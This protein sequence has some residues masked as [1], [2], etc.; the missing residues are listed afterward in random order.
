[1]DETFT[2]SAQPEPMKTM[3]GLDTSA[4]E[5]YYAQSEPMKMNEGHV[6]FAGVFSSS[7]RARTDNGV[8]G[9]PKIIARM[10]L[11]NKRTLERKEIGKLRNGRNGQDSKLGRN[12]SML[13]SCNK[14][15]LLNSATKK[16]VEK[17]GQGI[18]EVF[19]NFHKK[20]VEKGGVDK[21]SGSRFD[22]LCEEMDTLMSKRVLKK[23]DKM[24][25]LK[26]TFKGVIKSKAVPEVG[27][28]DNRVSLG[29]VEVNMDED[30][31]D[32]ESAYSCRPVRRDLL[33]SCRY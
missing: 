26:K 3:E 27:V 4:G 10:E 5:F 16:P 30:F 14:S 22:V 7:K 17:V 33:L 8:F 32:S 19:D 1:M 2:F 25:P 21:A 23:K 11:W 12:G 28:H 13:H 15:G 9:I 6:S 31:K 24:G 18:K 29:L 20:N